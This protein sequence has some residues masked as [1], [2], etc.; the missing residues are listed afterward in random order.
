MPAPPLHRSLAVWTVV[1][2][3]AAAAVAWLLPVAAGPPAPAAGFDEVLVRI[4]AVVALGAVAWLWL[5]T[6]VTIAAALRGRDG[7][8][9]GVP[10]P[11][12]RVVLAACGLALTG[13][14]VAGPAHATPG[15][16][17]EGRTVGPATV[18]AGLPLPDRAVAPAAEPDS[19][20]GLGRVVVSP[21]DSLW[22]IAA[23]RL[24]P[25]ASNAEIDAEW[26]RI[27][28]VN[29]SEIGADPDLITPAQR[30]RMPISEVLP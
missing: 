19:P 13:G 29:R 18:V 5:T 20:S 7:C 30:L 24:G 17:Y 16:P 21:G 23:R 9:R 14:L 3:A 2:A 4:C 1:T 11:V 6:G 28:A 27:Y 25:G 26:R 15:R 10:D 8:A 12:R 22:A